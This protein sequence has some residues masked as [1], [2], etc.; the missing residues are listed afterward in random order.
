MK[1]KKRQQQQK[2]TIT[3]ARST[4]MTEDI[5][6]C[7]SADEAPALPGAYVIAIEL[8]KTVAVVLSGRSPIILP[9]GHYLY[10]GS[11]KGPGGLKARLSR[12]MRRGKSVRWHVDQ[13]T[14][15]GLVI[16]SW[17]RW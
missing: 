1:I 17:I 2:V 12:H 11:A 9:T 5:R 7:P 15:H 10:C 3:G 6:F 4:F 16:G 14:E 13:L 8:A